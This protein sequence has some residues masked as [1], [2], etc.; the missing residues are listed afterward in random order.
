M[1]NSNDRPDSS[2][3]TFRREHLSSQ[4]QGSQA[5]AAAAGGGGVWR[6]CPH[7]SQDGQRRHWVSTHALECQQFMRFNVDIT[8]NSSIS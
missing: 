6:R 2:R 1:I 8:S 7:T 4:H 3:P 5:T